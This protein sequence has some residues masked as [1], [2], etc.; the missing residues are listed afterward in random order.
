MSKQY[1]W[2]PA[3]GE[4][5]GEIAAIAA[6]VHAGHPEAETVFQNRLSLYP[7]GCLLL[8]ERASGRAAGYLLSHP[9]RRAD[10]I[11]LDSLIAR[12]PETPDCLYLHD[13]A[14]LSKTR[15][16]GMGASGLAAVEAIARRE[17]LSEIVLVALP[18]ALRFWEETGFRPA[19]KA[20]HPSYGAGAACLVK[21]L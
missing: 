18:G 7:E 19:G 13:I 9:W 8:T 15:G 20:A 2:T 1:H 3:P 5:A 14:L 16:R 4:A 11:A 21:R 6:A 17:G 12:L 10:S